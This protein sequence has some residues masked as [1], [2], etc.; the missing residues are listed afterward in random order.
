M[1]HPASLL[2]SS[3]LLAGPVL[4][5]D[6]KVD[7]THSNVAFKVSH[8]GFSTTLGRF[9][10]FEGSYFFDGDNP[11]ASKVNLS[12]Q[13][14]SVDTNH[15]PRDKHLR[16]PDFFDVRQ[17]PTMTF[18]STAY[19]GTK[20]SGK[21][22]G[23]LTLH[24]VTK[25]VTLDVAFVGEGDDPWG[26]FRNG[27]NAVGKIKRSDYGMEYGLPGIGDDIELNVFVEGIRQ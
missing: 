6:F 17:Y 27:F 1:K 18:T 4:A 9:N 7:E 20:E 23:D 13:A 21:L 24:G 16:S 15:E 5:A 25:P 2:L 22:T 26:S 3:I 11:A 8:M 12:I 14:D 19:E 10:Q